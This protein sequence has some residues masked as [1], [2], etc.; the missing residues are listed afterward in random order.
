MMYAEQPKGPKRQP[1]TQ[2]RAYVPYMGHKN[3]LMII[4]SIYNVYKAIKRPK[5]SSVET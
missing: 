5:K 1:E 4:E 2:K 3:V